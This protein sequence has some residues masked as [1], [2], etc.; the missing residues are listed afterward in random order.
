MVFVEVLGVGARCVLVGDDEEVLRVVVLRGVRVVEA[1]GEY[2]RLVDDD[3]LVVHDRVS[4]VDPG[5]GTQGC[6]G[7]AEGVVVRVLEWI[8]DESDREASADCAIEGGGDGFGGKGVGGDVKRGRRVIE[9][10]YDGG[11][12][13]AAWGKVDGDGR[14]GGGRGG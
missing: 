11:R 8:E 6:E 4:F 10:G 2:G 12:A 5:V 1:A 3:V 14:G 13:A 9:A 7:R